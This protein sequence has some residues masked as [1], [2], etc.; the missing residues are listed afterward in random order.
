LSKNYPSRTLYKDSIYFSIRKLITSIGGLY[1]KDRII[2]YIE[3]INNKKTR[4]HYLISI[5]WFE[6]FLMEKFGLQ[7]FIYYNELKNIIGWH[8][9]E[10]LDIFGLS[11]EDVIK[12]FHGIS[13]EEHRVFYALLTVTGLRLGEARGIHIKDIDLDNRIIILN[14]IR[15]TKRVYISF[16]NSEVRDMIKEYLEKNKLDYPFK[17]SDRQ[18]KQL[19]KQASANAQTKISAQRLRKF[20][21]TYSIE[22]GMSPLLVD[23][24]QGRVGKSI[25]MKHYLRFDIKLLR[26]EYDKVWEGFRFTSI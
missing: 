2:K 21:A 26:K 19:F 3:G 8:S 12:G 22:N 17:L 4:S 20:F 10:P 18:I 16:F 6:K 9:S 24:L 14:K 7:D 11:K 15:K 13:K 1:D 5:K 25:L 23:F